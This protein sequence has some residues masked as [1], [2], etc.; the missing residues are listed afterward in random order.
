MGGAQVHESMVNDSN[1]FRT[2]ASYIGVMGTPQNKMLDKDG[3]THP[4]SISMT[5]PVLNDGATMKFFLPKEITKI[6][7]APIPTDSRVQIVEL[8]E[9][10]MLVKTFSGNTDMIEAKEIAEKLA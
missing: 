4:E 3:T 2:L 7:E 9:R 6:S 10:T 1:S 5:A 8:P